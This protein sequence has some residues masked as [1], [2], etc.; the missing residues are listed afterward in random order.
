MLAT[1]FRKCAGAFSEYRRKH[2]IPALLILRAILSNLNAMLRDIHFWKG[3]GPGISKPAFLK[4]YLSVLAQEV[5]LKAGELGDP[6]L[7]WVRK[8]LSP[9]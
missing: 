4:S 1:V 8:I 9:D 7:P 2:L 3:N 5:R 6:P